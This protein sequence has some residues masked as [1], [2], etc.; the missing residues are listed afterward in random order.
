MSN[1]ITITDS[2]V[3]NVLNYSDSIVSIATNIR[4]EG[5]LFEPAMNEQQP[6]AIPLSFAEIRIVNSQSAIFREGKLYFDE[7]Y[8]EE[9]YKKLGIYEWENILSDSQIRDTILKPTK[10]KLEKIIKINS[11]SMFDRVRGML[12]LMRNTGMYDISMR[13]IDVINYRYQEL[14]TGK[15]VT[16]IVINET[17]QEVSKEEIISR[18]LEKMKLEFESQ[19]KEMMKQIREELEE[20][21][22]KDNTDKIDKKEVKDSKVK[23]E[24]KETE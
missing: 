22:K 7:E 10:S 9:V 16:E 3:I 5:Y 20:Q 14:Y 4:P 2:S 18:E 19:K 24:K 15:K 12:V 1:N 23:N 8:Q 6:F 11:L 13:V 21:Y 17:N